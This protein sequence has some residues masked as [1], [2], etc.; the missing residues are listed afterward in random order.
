MIWPVVVQEH[1][2]VTIKPIGC[3][4]TTGSV[5]EP[6]WRKLN[7][8]LNLYFHFFA[9]VS[10]QSAALSSAPQHAMTPEIGGKCGTECLNT[11]LPLPTPPCA[12][13]SVK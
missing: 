7:I 6:L 10:R 2:C 8:Y 13:Y 9:F 4:T 5:E 1:K 3:G 12:E 11:R